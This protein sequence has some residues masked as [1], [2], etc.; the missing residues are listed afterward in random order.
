MVIV[1]AVEGRDDGGIARRQRG[2]WWLVK[3][4]WSWAMVRK[5]DGGRGSHCNIQ[6]I[7]TLLN[8]F[9]RF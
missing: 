9:I 5:K 1:R 2:E 3:G 6:K 4:R 7:S 8:R